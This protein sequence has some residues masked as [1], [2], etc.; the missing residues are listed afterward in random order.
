[1]WWGA[2]GRSVDPCEHL[3]TAS[4]V[5][6]SAG[7]DESWQVRKTF[8]LNQETNQNREADFSRWEKMFDENNR[9]AFLGSQ[10]FITFSSVSQRILS[11]FPEITP[12]R[13]SKA[14]IKDI[15]IAQ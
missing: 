1:M 6:G 11:K 13:K 5:P 3:V 15:A 8:S 2:E 12:H 9:E 4:L 7:Q 10:D 14:L